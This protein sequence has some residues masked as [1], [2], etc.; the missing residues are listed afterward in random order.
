[1]LHVGMT[2]VKY[3]VIG[4]QKAFKLGEDTLMFSPNASIVDGSVHGHQAI[5]FLSPYIPTVDRGAL[6][7]Q[8]L[9]DAI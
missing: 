5:V 1:M 2:Q 8:T 4:T 6:H 7:G 3:D 9:D